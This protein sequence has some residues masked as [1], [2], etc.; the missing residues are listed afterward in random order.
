VGARGFVLRPLA[1]FQGVAGGARQA[2]GRDGSEETNAVP[3]GGLEKKI[4]WYVE[5]L[6][7]DAFSEVHPARDPG[8]KRPL[9]WACMN[10]AADPKNRRRA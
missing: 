3:L 1:R 6:P 2:L 8:G 10:L 7:R 9:E 5:R 4:E